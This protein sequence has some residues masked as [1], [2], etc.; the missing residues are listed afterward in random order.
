M[1]ASTVLDDTIFSIQGRTIPMECPG[2]DLDHSGQ[3]VGSLGRH[4]T[5]QMA[6]FESD[7]DDD[8]YGGGGQK[9]GTTMQR[10]TE[11]NYYYDDTQALGHLIYSNK[12]IKTMFN[13]F[14]IAF[15]LIFTTSGT[16]L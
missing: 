7:D 15:V 13:F 3:F 6:G 16:G 9:F 11:E 12:I 1:I 5:V 10:C 2:S 8:F 14:F 4:E